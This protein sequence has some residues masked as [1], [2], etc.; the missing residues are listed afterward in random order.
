[1]GF[2]LQ[3]PLLA[4][5]SLAAGLLA[6]RFRFAASAAAG[7][8]GV[9][10]TVGL[11]AGARRLGLGAVPFA[12]AGGELVAAAWLVVALHR[13]G[14]P[15]LRALTWQRPPALVRFVRLIA[16][17]IGGAAVV[18]VNPIVDQLVA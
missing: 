18:R 2:A 7:I 14:I 17:E 4:L 10:V 12:I 16:A 11:A 8:A 5:R 15:V 3:L 9:A 1:L 6:A 13:A